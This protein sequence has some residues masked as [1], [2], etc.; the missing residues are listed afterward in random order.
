MNVAGQPDQEILAIATMNNIMEGS[1]AIDHATH[2]K[3]FSEQL[4]GTVTKKHLDLLYRL[5]QAESE[6]FP[7]REWIAI[8]RG[9]S[10]GTI[11]RKRFFIH[12]FEGYG[13]VPAQGLAADL[14]SRLLELIEI[15]SGVQA[16]QSECIPFQKRRNPF[17]DIPGYQRTLSSFGFKNLIKP[18]LFPYLRGTS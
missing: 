1:T 4:K 15:P 5:Y 6:Y 18:F 16:T 2:T 7:R 3:D 9:P 8:V 14:P 13:H 10:W 11:L 17:R 12:R